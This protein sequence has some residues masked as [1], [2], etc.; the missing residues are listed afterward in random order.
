MKKF[1]LIILVIAAFTA[2]RC[3]NIRHITGAVYGG[4]DKLP[5]P[6]ALVRVDG[7]TDAIAHTKTD[8][9]YTIDV[10]EGK[11]Q[12][13]FSSKNFKGRTI[14]IGKTDN[15][16]VY[17]DPVTPEMPSN[18]YQPRLKNN[19][20]TSTADTNAI[21][22]IMSPAGINSSKAQDANTAQKASGEI[23]RASC[24]ERV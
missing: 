22:P 12:L 3:N 5:I 13:V 2:F 23:G 16:N 11:N 19:D 14:V 21:L 10:P 15:I 24:R 20:N 6:G 8:G 1:I 17:L 7:S 9:S 18:T 4:D